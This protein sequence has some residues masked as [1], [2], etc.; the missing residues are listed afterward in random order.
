MYEVRLLPVAVGDLG[1]IAN[2][3]TRELGSPAA[4]ERFLEEFDQ[5]VSTLA[6]LSYRRRV[7]VPIRPLAHEFRALAVGSYLA[8]YWIEEEPAP[9]VVVARVLYARSD[10]A[11][12]LNVT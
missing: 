2:Y 9:V 7:Y 4:A 1:S 11:R 5:R 8:F 12:Q 6:D 10:Y 3:M